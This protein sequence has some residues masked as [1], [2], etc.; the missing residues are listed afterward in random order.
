MTLDALLTVSFGA[1]ERRDDVIPF[2][3]NVL[4]AIVNGSC[5]P[6][7]PVLPGRF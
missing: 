3:E 1:L 5:P 7:K 2:L 6:I 4:S